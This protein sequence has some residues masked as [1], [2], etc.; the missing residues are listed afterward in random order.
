MVLDLFL[1]KQKTAILLTVVFLSD[2]LSHR[3]KKINNRKYEKFIKITIIK[4]RQEHHCKTFLF[5][6]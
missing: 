6:E 2:L 5:S 4:K 1:G 3:N